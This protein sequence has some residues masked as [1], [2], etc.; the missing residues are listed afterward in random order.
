MRSPDH[1]GRSSEAK[2]HKSPKEVKCDGR[3]DGRTDKADLQNYNCGIS[4][5]RPLTYQLKY[6]RPTD[7]RAEPL[8]VTMLRYFVK[9]WYVDEVARGLTIVMQVELGTSCILS[10]N[11]VYKNIGLR[12]GKKIRTS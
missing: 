12:F 5:A 7:R 11:T 6:Y 10:K 1:L 3:T 9:T 4:K 2:K 8:I